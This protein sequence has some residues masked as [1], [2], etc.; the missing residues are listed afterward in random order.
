VVSSRQFEAAAYA[1]SI[2][3]LFARLERDET[4]PAHRSD[5]AS[6]QIFWRDNLGARGRDAS[7]RKGCRAHGIVRRLA[8]GAIE[9]DRGT[10]P[11]AA[12]ALC[13]DCTGKRIHLAADESRSSMGR[14]SLF[15]WSVPASPV[16]APPSWLMW[17]PPITMRSQKNELCTPLRLPS[18]NVDWL[19]W[20]LADLRNARRW[21]ADK[22]LRRWVA[23]ASSV[24]C[25]RRQHR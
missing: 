17:K 4:A 16:S 20:A 6:H 19:R 8:R 5:R 3:D 24:G 7:R 9:L 23:G 18:T 15:S 10:V 12:N 1:T 2:D 13:I 25:G 11:L 22:D 14:G 21:G